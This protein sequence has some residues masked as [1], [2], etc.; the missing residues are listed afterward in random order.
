MK[1]LV[2][3]ILFIIAIS[4]KH[5]TLEIKLKKN[6]IEDFK[7]FLDFVEEY[8]RNDT[9]VIDSFNFLY[10]SLKV[11]YLNDSAIVFTSLNRNKF[12][13]FIYPDSISYYCNYPDLLFY[14]TIDIKEDLLYKNKIEEIIKILDN[15]YTIV[16]K[17]NLGN[18]IIDYIIYNE[19]YKGCY[20]FKYYYY[21]NQLNCIHW[22]YSY[23]KRIK[24]DFIPLN[25]IKFIR[26]RHYDYNIKYLKFP[27]G[28]RL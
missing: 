23:I 6:H 3:P 14:S 22:N 24:N 15:N 19:E 2:V 13:L 4:C 21:L 16:Y 5:E 1:R 9:V 12:L 27:E 10:N 11:I 8:K 18:R 25:K 26:H 7:Y 17:Y 20:I 28:I